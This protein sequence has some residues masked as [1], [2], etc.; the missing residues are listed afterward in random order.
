MQLKYVLE[1]R[2]VA[3]AQAQR[4]PGDP[5]PTR[6]PVPAGVQLAAWAVVL[7]CVAALYLLLSRTPHRLTPLRTALSEADR[8]DHPVF[9]A[10]LVLVAVGG[11][12]IVVPVSYSLA[13]RRSARPVGDDASVTVTFDDDAVTLRTARKQLRVKW[14]GVAAVAESRTLFVL[15]TVGDVRVIVPK[16]AAGSPAAV[17]WLRG[18][19]RRRVLPMATVAYPMGVAA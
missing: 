17:D 2:D 8:I 10:G 16:R 13:R 18:E 14:E 5:A 11:A 1:Y 7:L 3:E 9:V 15:K 4:F 6:A 12:M 19:L